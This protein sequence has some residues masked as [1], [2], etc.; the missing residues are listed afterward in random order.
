MMASPTK[1]FR[2]RNKAEPSDTLAQ[3]QT[4]ARTSKSLECQLER[5]ISLTDPDTEQLAIAFLRNVV[6]E[7]KL[8]LRDIASAEDTLRKA[9]DM[10]QEALEA[11]K[12]GQHQTDL[13]TQDDLASLGYRVNFRYLQLSF[14]Q[15]RREK[16]LINH[17]SSL[18]KR[19]VSSTP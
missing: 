7:L 11:W 4:K 3:L 6:N 10:D 1:F 13:A 2:V 17:S 19:R 14:E 16:D 5:L 8:E 12:E 9:A 18:K 15:A